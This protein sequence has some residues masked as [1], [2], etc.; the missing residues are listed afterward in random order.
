MLPRTDPRLLITLDDNIADAALR[1]LEALANPLEAQILGP[2]ILR[3]IYFRVLRGPQGGAIRTAMAGDGGFGRIASALQ[4]IQSEFSRSLTV[5]DLAREAHLSV[6]AFHAHFKA[7]THT[8]PLQYL[9]AIR[10]HQARLLMIRDGSTAAA[11]VG[12]ASNSQFGREFK[13]FFGRTPVE[14]VRCMK[15]P[16]S[17]SPHREVTRFEIAH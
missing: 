17:L 12:Y 9:K 14:E 1:L 5:A 2:A 10:L 4:R 6:P 13:R 3:E 7:V 15:A 11:D 16:F 8:S